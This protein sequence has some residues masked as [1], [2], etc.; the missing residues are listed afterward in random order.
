MVEINNSST[1]E[2]LINNKGIQLFYFYSDSCGVC[3]VIK[4]FL[5][6]EIK[7]LNRMARYKI[8]I[9]DNIEEYSR[10]NI[11]TLP[12]ILVYIDGKEYI[13]EA[14]NISLRDLYIDIERLYNMYYI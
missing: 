1:I 6:S 12:V 8:F 10:F 13:R 7:Q 3:H 9:N 5:E 14:R 11:F 2:S 4:N